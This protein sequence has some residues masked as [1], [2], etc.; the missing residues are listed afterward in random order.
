VSRRWPASTWRC[1]PGRC[2]RS[3]PTTGFDPAARKS[4]WEV[5]AGLRDLGK[6]IFLA[7]NQNATAFQVHGGGLIVGRIVNEFGIARRVTEALRESLGSAP[8]G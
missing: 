7:Q 6:T 1:A 8:A 4:A 5:I 3:E 2:S